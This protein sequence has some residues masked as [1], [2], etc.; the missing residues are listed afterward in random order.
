MALQRGFALFSYDAHFQ[1][2]D[3]LVVVQG[4]ADLLL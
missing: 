2:V 1:R 3:G 4:V